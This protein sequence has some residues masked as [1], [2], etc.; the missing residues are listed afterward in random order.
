MN[1]LIKI[2][3]IF[4]GLVIVFAFVNPE[5]KV[6]KLVAKV[7]KNQEVSLSS[8]E[9]PDTLAAEIT[10]LDAVYKDG[11]IV[12]YACY[13]TAFGCR[14]GGCAAATQGTVQANETFD[15]IVIY[16]QNLLI[17]KIDI[18]NYSGEYGF[19]I[20]RPKWLTQFIG[21]TLGFELEKNIDGISGATVSA[22]F[23]IEDLNAL[24]KTMNLLIIP[25]DTVSNN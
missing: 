2:S 8:M 20:C 21:K 14:I 16:D 24:G 5:K 4:I 10:S 3:S 17:L 7:W 18:A 1:K 13:A 15:Y 23:L 6:N 25:E 12:G 11:E 22:S 9:V 19:E